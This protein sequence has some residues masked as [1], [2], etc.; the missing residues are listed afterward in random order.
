MEPGQSTLDIRLIRG[1]ITDSHADVIVNAA[2]ANLFPGGGVC[3]AI[4]DKAG[5]AL[6]RETTYI[7]REAPFDKFP[8]GSAVLTNGYWLAPWVV[9][10][11]GPIWGVTNDAVTMQQLQ[12]AYDN[13]LTIA[14]K[15]GACSIAFPLIST[16]IYQVPLGI[17]ISTAFY[18]IHQFNKQAE[19]ISSLSIVEIWAYT[20]KDYQV[21]LSAQRS[22]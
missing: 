22:Q 18:A 17:S 12:A 7:M 5:D 8:T 14:N 11:I 15:I 1:N 2:N 6:E 19:G 16:G 10:A 21:L 4:Y 20:E 3:G 13:S 9:H